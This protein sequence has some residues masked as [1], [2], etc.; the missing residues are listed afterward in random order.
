MS[1]TYELMF[2]PS[3]QSD[4]YVLV[5]S[6]GFSVA[7][8]FYATPT[9]PP[10][11]DRSRDLAS[12]RQEAR[13]AGFPVITEEARK[14][15][16]SGHWW[17]RTQKANRHLQRRHAVGVGQP[18]EPPRPRDEPRFASHPQAGPPPFPF[19]DHQGRALDSLD[20]WRSLH[21]AHHWKA[22]YSAMELARTWHSAG[23]FP[24]AVARVVQAEPFGG[25]TLDHAIAECRTPVPGGRRPSQTDLMVQARDAA[26][27]LVVVAVEG[28]VNE[29]F[30]PFVAAWIRSVD[31]SD[32]PTDKP[33]RLRC[34]CD[35]LS[36]AVDDPSTGRL[37]Y[38]LLHRT[39]AAL[40]HAKRVGAPVAVLLVHS[41]ATAP[42][43]DNRAAFHAFLRAMGQDEFTT[44]KLLPV[45]SRLGVELWAAWVCDV[46]LAP[47]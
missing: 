33:E 31:T 44:G 45:G 47:S 37:R 24:P 27:R 29:P 15:E 20:G 4:S 40:A 10:R 5:T 18:T 2:L 8:R 1:F 28:K 3:V 25:L 42:D 36:L 23:G 12:V 41:F 34:L 26:G 16:L 46:P 21:K 14:T 17:D 19:V 39:W 32:S 13:V 9:T 22:G 7:V 6:R 11:I 43:R 38:Q 35:A 30:G